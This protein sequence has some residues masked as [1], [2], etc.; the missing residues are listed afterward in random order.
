[1]IKGFDMK[2][3]VALLFLASSMTVAAALGENWTS[4]NFPQDDQHRGIDMGAMTYVDKGTIKKQGNKTLITGITTFPNGRTAHGV[5]YTSGRSIHECD[6]RDGSHNVI[7][8]TMF[9][10][11]DATGKN[12]GAVQKPVHRNYVVW[13]LHS[14]RICQAACGQPI[15]P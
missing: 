9:A 5:N 4:V 10:G 12:L 15:K 2:K 11:P 6:C 14:K 3:T 1:M 8:A 13:A 7:A